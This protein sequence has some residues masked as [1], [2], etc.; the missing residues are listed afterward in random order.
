MGYLEKEGTAEG[1][2]YCL[3]CGDV[4]EYGHGRPD[5]KFCS[6]A[7]KNRWHN[8]RKAQSWRRYEQ[9]VL[10]ILEDNHEILDKLIRIGLSSIDR[11]SLSRLGYDFNY[12]TSYHKVGHRDLYSCFDITYEATP[13]R[14]FR[15]ASHWNGGKGEE[16]GEGAASGMK[17]GVTLLSAA[18]GD[19]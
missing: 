16:P 15:L 12:V 13:S 10:R 14:I 7:C 11:I 18:S 4:I 17:N 9:R 2:G 8:Q 6:P 19:L 5:R 1:I 3:A